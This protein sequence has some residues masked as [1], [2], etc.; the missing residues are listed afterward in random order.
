MQLKKIIK[1]IEDNAPKCY[2]SHWDN[3][4]LM[5]GDVEQ[6][7]KKIMLTLDVTPQVTDEAIANE[8]DLIISHH[9][10]FFSE[11]KTIDF[12]TPYGK[13]IKNLI[14]NNIAVFSCHTNMDS[15][16]CGINAVL[17]EKF[18]LSDVEVLEKNETFSEVGIGRIGNIC[19]CT[20]DEICQM[21]KKI[22]NASTLRVI[23]DDMDK[24]IKKV[25][26][27]SGS[28]GDLI[29]IA[30]SKS[31]DVFIT[32]DVKYHQAL[33]AS[34]SDIA[35]IDAGH[36]YT[37][38]LVTDIFKSILENIDAEIFISSQKDCFRFI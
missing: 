34:Y 35:V 24:Q 1:L 6:E 37:E 26:V 23:A 16:E 19:E 7:I 11:I 4:G 28:C 10:F 36:Y 5:L 31:A 3:V 18:E 33:D 25:C 29:G 21:T 2:A 8:C 30:K 27:A 12:S 9:P 14:T 38:F 17:S 20:L 32:A 13:M 15:A 22:L